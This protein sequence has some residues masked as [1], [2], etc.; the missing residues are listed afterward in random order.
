[1]P[2]FSSVRE[3]GEDLQMK[4]CKPIRR[5]LTDVAALP[6]DRLPPSVRDHLTRCSDCARALAAARLARGLVSVV[7]AAPEPPQEFARRVLAALPARPARRPTEQGLWRTA[8]GL[9]PAFA[10]TAAGLF[11]LFQASASPVA[12]GLVPTA[13]LSVGERLVLE[14]RPPD[15]DSVLAAVMEG[16]E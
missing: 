11:V 10:A 3:P 6:A 13:N 12:G 8:W 14:E 5:S 2:S 9:V 7:T 16:A 1:M 15:P 4:S